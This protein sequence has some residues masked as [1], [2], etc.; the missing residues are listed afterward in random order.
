MPS[1]DDV[2]RGFGY[3]AEA[4]QLLETELGTLLF[5][6]RCEDLGLLG[7]DR[8]TEARPILEK[9]NRSTLGSLLEKIGAETSQL[10]HVSEELAQALAER[11]RL[12]HHFY[13]Q[14][15]NRRNSEEGRAIMVADLEKIHAVIFA[16]YKIV[17]KIVGIDLDALDPGAEP[18]TKHVKI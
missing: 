15:N 9:I 3:A 1:I 6:I 16:A 14:H 12:S 5:Q 17:L 18:P 4:A 7:G 8:G 13:R 2:Y 11:N 10:A